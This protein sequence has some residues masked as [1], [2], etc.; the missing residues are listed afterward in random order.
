MFYRHSYAKLSSCP[1]TEPASNLQ[2]SAGFFTQ[3]N[4]HISIF[5]ALSS[6][7]E[8]T[9]KSGNILVVISNSA[10]PTAYNSPRPPHD[11]N[12]HPHRLIRSAF[13]LLLFRK[14]LDRSHDA[15]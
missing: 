6:S 15:L 11:N 4:F 13:L 1:Q 12:I 10:Q 9:G 2:S 7:V 8:Q 3:A 14:C 5:S